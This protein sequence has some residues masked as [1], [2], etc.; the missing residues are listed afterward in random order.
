M[1]KDQYR[2]SS[3]ENVLPSIRLKMHSLRSYSLIKIYIPMRSKKISNNKKLSIGN[4]RKQFVISAEEIHYSATY[5]EKRSDLYFYQMVKK[6]EITNF[7]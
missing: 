4:S 1:K 3:G 5:K 6:F 2:D 7:I